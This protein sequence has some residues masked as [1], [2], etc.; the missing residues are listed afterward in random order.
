M[1]DDSWRKGMKIC[2][3][4]GSMRHYNQM[5]ALAN[6]L[7]LDGWIV[8]LPF[9]LK[10]DDPG[11]DLLLQELHKQKI[12]LSHRVFVVGYPGESTL[13]EICYAKENSIPIE[14]VEV[15]GASAKWTMEAPKWLESRL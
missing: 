10:V 7:T 8:L 12:S 14:Y 9:V 6:E 1:S 13:D 4:S 2:T 5:L 3:V 15:K 11:M